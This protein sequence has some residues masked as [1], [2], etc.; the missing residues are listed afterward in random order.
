MRHCSAGVDWLI[1]LNDMRSRTFVKDRPA[2][3]AWRESRK[4]EIAWFGCMDG[5][6]HPPTITGTHLGI[7]SIWQ[8]IGGKFDLAKWP[9]FQNSFEKF[10]WCSKRNDRL[11]LVII[12]YHFSRSDNARL[13]CKGHGFDLARAQASSRALKSQFEH[14][15]KD[16]PTTYVISV[17]IDTDGDSMVFHGQNGEIDIATANDR[18]ESFFRDEFKRIDPSMP[19]GFLPH[20]V[21]IAMLN[22]R[23]VTQVSNGQRPIKDIEHGEWV[24]AV[25]QGFDWLHTLNTAI[26]I[27]PFDPQFSRWVR[28]GARILDGNSEREDFDWRRGLVLMA[29][30]Q[31]NPDQGSVGQRLAEFKARQLADQ[32]VTAIK[33]SM[34]HLLEHL[35]RVTGTVDMGTRKFHIL[36]SD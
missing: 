16:E 10:W 4:I 3:Q 36:D 29:S 9:R 26:I 32:A 27:G 8:N 22:G 34:P 6:F 31:F 33:N 12:T 21:E 14:V 13:G 1:A 19:D 7:W 15:F 25:G 28:I 20:V 5:R 30:A 23:H 24:L 2:R 11:M 18:S 17:G 35:Q